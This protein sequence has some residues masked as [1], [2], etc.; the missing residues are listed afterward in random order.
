MGATARTITEVLRSE[1]AHAPDARELRWPGL[2]ATM[3][4]GSALFGAAMGT[5]SL[6]PLQGLYS[7]LKTPLLLACTSLVCLPNF[8]VLNIVLGL[9]DDMR[10]A[11][12]GII[13]AQSTVALC[14][15]GLA[16]LVLFGYISGVTY[17]GAKLL[18]GGAFL[19]ASLAGQWTLRRHYAPLIARDRRHRI[20][21]TA[22]LLLY[23]LVAIQLAWS[24]RPFIGDPDT[25]TTFF[26]EESFTNAYVE[27][28][29]AIR[30]VLTHGS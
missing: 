25:A 5:W 26:R 9:G 10:A 13:A 24:L 22:W 4:L 16:P 23:Q 29:R 8:Y 30:G 6:S 3:L 7:A 12:R 28:T 18:N 15:A 1:G 11:L 17:P 21:V 14:L 27:V 20:T 2:L 19:L